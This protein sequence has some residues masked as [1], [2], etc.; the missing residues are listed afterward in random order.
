VDVDVT[1]SVATIRV[2]PALTISTLL[3]NGDRHGVI[4]HAERT[5]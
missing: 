5:S 1:E 2:T 3:R 4:V